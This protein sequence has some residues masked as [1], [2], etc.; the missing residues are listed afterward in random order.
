MAG[1]FYRALPMNNLDQYFHPKFG[2]LPLY[3]GWDTVPKN[4]VTEAVL[5]ER[6]KRPMPTQRPVAVVQIQDRKRRHRYVVYNEQDAVKRRPLTPRQKAALDRVKSRNNCRQCGASF[7]RLS[8]DGLCEDCRGP[9][10]SRRQARIEAVKWAGKVARK[11]FVVLD[12]ETTGLSVWDKIVEIAVIDEA[13]KVLLN[14]LVDPK[15]LIPSKVITIHGI[16]NDMVQGRPLFSDIVP[17]LENILFG[18]A[19]VVYNVDF[20]KRFLAHSGLNVDELNF[21]CAML[22]YS[23]FF[24]KWSDHYKG[25]RRQSLESACAF[26]NIR[27]TTMHRAVVDC[28]ATRELV[29]YMARANIENFT[30]S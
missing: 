17:Q 12:T 23:K 19:V 20:D 14:T 27:Y 18:K 1:F 25:W 16:T 13:G 30:V 9:F 11:P 4:F 6:G 22:A 7:V 29:H 10:D 26:C 28:E 3:Y 2:E 21:Q 5:K 15:M 24:G 8:P